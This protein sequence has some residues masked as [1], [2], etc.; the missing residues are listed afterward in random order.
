MPVNRFFSSSPLAK[1]LTYYIEGKELHHLKNVIRLQVGSAIELIDGEGSLGLGSIEAIDK[2]KACVSLTEVKFYKPSSSKLVLAQ[3][4]PS[5]NHLDLILEKG[6]ELGVDEFWIFHSKRATKLPRE[7]KKERFYNICISALKQ[8]GRYYLPKIQLIPSMKA[9]P[10]FIGNRFFG[11]IRE[12][13]LFYHEPIETNT[14]LIIGPES[15]FTDDE[16][17]YLEDHFFATGIKLSQN[18]LRAETAAIAGCAMM[19]SLY[20][21]THE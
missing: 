2:T 10:Q 8:S 6:C 13:A 3:A 4:M 20:R 7:E 17:Q 14:L 1:G 16:V 15:G 5:M 12:K 18:V 11:D 9:F 21:N 19:A